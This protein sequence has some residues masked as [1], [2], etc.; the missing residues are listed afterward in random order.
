[1]GLDEFA[2]YLALPGTSSRNQ[3]TARSRELK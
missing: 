2:G 1:M 3:D